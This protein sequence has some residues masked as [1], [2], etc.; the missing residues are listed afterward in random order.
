[1]VVG[2]F[3]HEMKKLECGR[4]SKSTLNRI[5]INNFK[6][7]FRRKFS[8]AYFSWLSV[9]VGIMLFVGV[10]SPQ[11]KEREELLRIFGG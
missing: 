5:T 11:T 4:L 9:F 1:M 8:M 10:L 2:C 6:K 7:Q 3:R